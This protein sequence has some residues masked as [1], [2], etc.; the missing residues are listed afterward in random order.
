MKR[1]HHLLLIPLIVLAS[2]ACAPARAAD[3]TDF[4]E[5]KV[6]DHFFRGTAYSPAGPWYVGLMTAAANCDT[7]SVTEVSGG[8][9]ARVSVTKADGSWKGTHGSATG[10]SSGT[11]GTIS[12][13]AAITFPAPTANWGVVTHFGVW[14][15]AS[16][17]NLILCKTLTQSKTINN[18]DAAPS[19]AIDA[20]T[21]QVDN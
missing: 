20:L 14:D 11:N 18:G 17:G 7:G 4:F 10:A 19:F 5:N 13:A 6:A 3:F 2:L 8:S 16:S 9:Y 12:N 1:L 21:V 15:A